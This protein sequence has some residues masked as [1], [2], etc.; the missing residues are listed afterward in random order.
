M[1]YDHARAAANACQP[2]TTHPLLPLLPQVWTPHEVVMQR[3]VQRRGGELFVITAT[4]T[5]G[6]I[7]LT[8][9]LNLAP[10]L[11]LTLNLTLP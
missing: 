1:S 7:T 4:G 2:I 6:K 5:K 3:A 9:T 8:Q 10:V 11:V